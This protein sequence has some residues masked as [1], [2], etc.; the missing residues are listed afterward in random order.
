MLYPW[1]TQ[2]GPTP[3]SETTPFLR[4]WYEYIAFGVLASIRTAFLSHVTLTRLSREGCT[5]VV[6]ERKR[7]WS[8]KRRNSCQSYVVM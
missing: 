7:T 8:S 4:Q 2:D 3:D 5:L 6:F 1:V